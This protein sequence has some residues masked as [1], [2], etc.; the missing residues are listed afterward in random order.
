MAVWF[1]YV[2]PFHER[3]AVAIGGTPWQS[4]DVTRF[5][6]ETPAKPIHKGAPDST[7]DPVRRCAVCFLTA[8]LQTA[9]VVEWS[10]PKLTLLC[11]LEV[12]PCGDITYPPAIT[13]P[14]SRGPPDFFFV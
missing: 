5:C 11:V 14:F 1:G 10:I 2:M 4:A 12:T 8:L 6:C 9:P 3:G 13:V 7:N